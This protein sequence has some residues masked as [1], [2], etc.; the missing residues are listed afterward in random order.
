MSS[1]PAEQVPVK[2]LGHRAARAGLIF[3]IAL[4]AMLPAVLAPIGRF[5]EGF[6]TSGAEMVRQGALPIRDFYVIYG[7]GQYVLWALVLEAFGPDLLYLRIA[8]AAVLAVVVV[9]AHDLARFLAGGREAPALVGAAAVALVLA[10]VPPNAGYP[11]LSALVFAMLS[12][13]VIGR[14]CETQAAWMLATASLLA[15]AGGVF[16]WDF[17]VFS[18]C[19]LTVPVLLSS[20]RGPGAAAALSGR[21]ALA[22]LPGALLLLAVYL[23]LLGGGLWR[24]WFDEVVLYALRT[25][26]VWRGRDLVGPEMGQLWQ[27]LQQRDLWTLQR[28]VNTLLLAALPVLAGLGTLVLVWL[29]WRDPTAAGRARQAAAAA[30][31]VLMLLLFNQMR[32]RPGFPQ[33]LPA[34]CV[35]LLLLSTMAGPA[36]QGRARL[37][38]G[39]QW[40]A[41]ALLAVCM[42]LC[43]A[44]VSADWRLL[45]SREVTLVDAPRAS[46]VRLP[47]QPDQAAE[48]RAYLQMI[49]EIQASTAPDARIFS[50]VQDT[51]RLFV[52]DS[53][54][55][56][57]ADRRA[58]VYFVEMEPGVA[59]TASG[60]A[61]IIAELERHQVPVAV[62]WAM[63]VDHEPNATSRSNGVHL[64]DNYLAEHYP[65]RQRYGRYLLARRR[66]G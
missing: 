57:L 38:Q 4:A 37:Q 11:A 60:Q 33:G 32:V 52:N 43:L 49:R 53:M 25:F 35:A 16:R 23:P 64:L 39:L 46:K 8:H 42:M 61:E 41:R 14:W 6:I 59:N 47:R 54:L 1:T 51:S 40:G 48:E 12:V 56:F 21:L 3:L 63:T 28:S 31:V 29:R 5:D 50:G 58:A 34:A 30:A 18:L 55:Y 22:C 44:I 9:V 19:S 17:G 27:A 66:P 36:Q 20:A 24:R 2:A 13:R 26:P 15:G 65:E 7:P 45:V 62:L 10:A